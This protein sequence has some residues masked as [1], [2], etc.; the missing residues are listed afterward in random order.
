ML[1]NLCDG[2][3]QNERVLKRINCRSRGKAFGFKVVVLR[4]WGGIKQPLPM[5]MKMN[6]LV[7]VLRH[8][9]HVVHTLCIT[10]D[11]SHLDTTAIVCTILRNQAFLF[12]SFLGLN[13]HIFV[14]KI[15]R[16][17]RSSEI[18]CDKVGKVN[19]NCEKVNLR[20]QWRYH[21]HTET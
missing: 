18:S 16:A 15:L 11:I 9:Y 13:H 6:P 8:L 4:A 19:F 14:R 3:F 17:Q 1:W 7:L 5:F 12:A 10:T 20:F 21:N 2:Q